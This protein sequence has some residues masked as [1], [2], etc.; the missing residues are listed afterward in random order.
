[1]ANSKLITVERDVVGE[2]GE[3]GLRGEGCGQRCYIFRP[4]SGV[5]GHGGSAV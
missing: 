5:Q 1:M 2:T 3:D 4:S